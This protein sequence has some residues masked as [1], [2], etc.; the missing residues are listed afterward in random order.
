VAGKSRRKHGGALNFEGGGSAAIPS[1]PFAK[2]WP[3][4][5]IRVHG[6]P[7]RHR[8][9]IPTG[10]SRRAVV[11]RMPEGRAALGYAKPT[12]RSTSMAM[13]PRRSLRLGQPAS[14]I[15][16]GAERGV[17]GISSIAL[18]DLA[19]RKSRLSRQTAG[20]CDRRVSSSACI[21]HGAEIVSDRA[22][23]G[24]HQRPP[25]TAKAFRRSRWWDLARWCATASA[26]AADIADVARGIRQAVRAPAERLRTPAR[27]RWATRAATTSA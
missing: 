25:S 26:V 24:R 3:A 12:P 23:D 4:G 6:N 2:G 20:R 18:E 8:N 11:C 14:A 13:I 21:H 7:Q 9:C 22:G 5:V 17:E 15:Q 1:R 27:R 10:W 19:L 16:G